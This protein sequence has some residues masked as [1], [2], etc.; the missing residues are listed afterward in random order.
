MEQVSTSGGKL[1]KFQ[2]VLMDYFDHILLK[3]PGTFTLTVVINFK[4]K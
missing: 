4:L 3:K 1:V 2:L